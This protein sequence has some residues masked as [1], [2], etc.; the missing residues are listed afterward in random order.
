MAVRGRVL[1][2]VALGLLGC[3]GGDAVTGEVFACTANEDCAQ[4]FWCS[5]GRCKPGQFECAGDLD[6][7]DDRVCVR[8]VC[9]EIGDGRCRQDTDCPGDKLCVDGQCAPQVPPPCGVDDD[10][11]GA[12]G[13][14][15]RAFLIDRHGQH[16][17]GE[18]DLTHGGDITY[19]RL[20]SLLDLLHHL[21]AHPED[22]AQWPLPR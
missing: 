5:G 7:P 20:E 13:A 3:D 9:S 16:A 8:Q 6:C 19:I 22:E 11:G 14:G 15:L 18:H 1:A 10:C 4:G 17:D 2:L 12:F 21:D